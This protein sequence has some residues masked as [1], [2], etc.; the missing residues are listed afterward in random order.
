MTKERLS[1]ET[2]LEL[3]GDAPRKMEES[4][5][6]VSAELLKIRPAPDEWSCVEI[7]AH[8]R[9]V[10]DTRGQYLY[11][12]L[13]GD[14]SFRPMDPRKYMAGTDYPSLEWA[15]SFA[16]F[17]HQRAEL[18][19][20]LSGLSAEEWHKSVQIKN[21]G[22]TLTVSVWG[23]ANGIAL[24]ERPHLKQLARTAALMRRGG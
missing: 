1:I 6:G 18:M 11:K 24:H 12:V 21:W 5:S 4:V 22:Q 8:L 16:V 10:I 17:K 14:S 9:S 3:L 15:E 20:T 19:N 23:Y 7:L 13:A 2:I